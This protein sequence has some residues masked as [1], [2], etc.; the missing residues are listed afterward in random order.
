VLHKALGQAIDVV[1]VEIA[2]RPALWRFVDQIVQYLVHHP[3]VEALVHQQSASMLEE[4]LDEVRRE[5]ARAD[6]AVDRAVHSLGR[7]LHRH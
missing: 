4:T 1:L 5:A 3:D 6:S 2:S 7:R